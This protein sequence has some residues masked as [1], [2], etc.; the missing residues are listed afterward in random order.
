MAPQYNHIWILTSSPLFVLPRKMASLS[1]QQVSSLNPSAFSNTSSLHSSRNLSP[2]DYPHTAWGTSYPF[3]TSLG[4]V[5]QST[6]MSKRLCGS[7]T[8][9]ECLCSTLSTLRNT[10]ELLQFVLSSLPNKIPLFL[11]WQC[12]SVGTVLAYHVWGPGFF[13]CTQRNS[14]KNSKKQKQ[15]RLFLW[16]FHS[17]N[18]QNQNI[19]S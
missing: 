2:E 3:H 15:E 1:R 8:S 10:K 9:C 4:Q 14:A 17:F 16:Q 7:Q 5:P 18:S 6:T 19:Q 13:P 11:G 12:A